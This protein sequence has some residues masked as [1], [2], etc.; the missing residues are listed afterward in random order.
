MPHGPFAAE[1]PNAH[2]FSF[3]EMQKSQSLLSAC[4]RLTIHKLLNYVVYPFLPAFLPPY[5][6]L[7]CHRQK[8]KSPNLD[9]ALGS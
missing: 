6:Y 4:V 5:N 7:K 9:C 8:H 2:Y 3:A 1:L